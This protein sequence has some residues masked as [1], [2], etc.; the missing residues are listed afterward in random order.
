M[1]FHVFTR[2]VGLFNSVAVG[3]YTVNL[4]QGLIYWQSQAFRKSS[5]VINIKRQSEIIRPY[6]SAG[7]YNFN[8]GVAATI[9]SGKFEGTLFFSA[10]KLE[11]AKRNQV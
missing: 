2:Q 3:D 7:E 1:S 5:A 8:R 4:G 10:K 9:S 11:A 6:H